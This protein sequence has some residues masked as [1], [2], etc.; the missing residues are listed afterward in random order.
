MYIWVIPGETVI[1]STALNV[2]LY[3][4]VQTEAFYL[5]LIAEDRVSQVCGCS[6]LRLAIRHVSPCSH[7]KHMAGPLLHCL[8]HLCHSSEMS[9]YLI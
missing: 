6:S 5:S 2:P 1:N 3:P 8:L 7:W 9:Q 4:L